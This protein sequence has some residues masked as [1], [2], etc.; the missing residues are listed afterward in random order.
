M[1][2]MVEQFPKK[3][4]KCK[5][6]DVDLEAFPI[7]KIKDSLLDFFF[8]YSTNY[9]FVSV[10]IPVCKSCKEQFIK[11]H[12]IKDLASI[13]KVLFG[14]FLFLTVGFFVILIILGVFTFVFIIFVLITIG[15]LFLFVIFYII[16]SNHPDKFSN[17]FDLKIRGNEATLVINDPDYRQDIIEYTTS[18]IVEDLSKKVLNIDIIYCPKCGSKQ[19]KEVDFCLACGKELRRIH[20]Y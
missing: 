14:L 16:K 18:K 5:R 10:K 8:G 1:F 3:C 9:R 11:Y 19:N 12:K 2:T 6:T 20:E 13:F 7:F 15:F 4:I 17:Y